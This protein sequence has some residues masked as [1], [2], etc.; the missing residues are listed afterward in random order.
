MLVVLDVLLFVTHVVVIVFNLTGWIWRR[1]QR[2]H[3]IVLVLTVLSWVLLGIWYG[4][5]YC[6]LTDWHWNVK[7]QLGEAGLPPSFTEFFTNNV[8]GLDLS[9]TLVNNMTL[10]ALIAAAVLSVWMNIKRK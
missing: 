1:T 2:L 3:L 4:W 7:R 5:G 10:W 6:F 9:T 8:M